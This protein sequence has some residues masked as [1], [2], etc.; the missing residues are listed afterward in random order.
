MGKKDSLVVGLDIGTTKI[1]TVVGEVADDQVNIIGL[2]TYPSKGLRKGVVINIESTVQS[3]K[4]AIE[5]ADLLA[6]CRT[7]SVYVG[8]AGGRWEGRLHI[9]PGA[10]T[11]AQNIIKCANRAGLNVDDIVL[12]QLG[13][14]EAVLTPEE[15]ELGVAILDIGGGT[16]DLVIF[17][18]R[19]IKKPA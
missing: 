11:S 12:E 15:K 7:T 10:I 5:E 19:A 8:M 3:I 16:T 2:G 9:V 14:S 17:A 6:G 18:H 1:C 13:S 4:K